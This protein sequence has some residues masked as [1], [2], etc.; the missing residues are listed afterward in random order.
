MAQRKFVVASLYSHFN[1][2]FF[3]SFFHG[4]MFWLFVWMMRITDRY[5][6]K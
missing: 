3:F 5:L 4:F 2:N 1:L 6:D